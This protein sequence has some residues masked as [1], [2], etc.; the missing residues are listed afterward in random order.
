MSATGYQN[1]WAALTAPTEPAAERPPLGPD[2]P[3]SD[4]ESV[5]QFFE[6]TGA[7]TPAAAPAR[8]RAKGADDAAKRT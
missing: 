8:S 4:L 7:S 3:Q 6:R 1:L 5:E 2:E